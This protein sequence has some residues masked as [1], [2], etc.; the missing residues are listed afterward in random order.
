MAF[1]K[2]G[3]TT[4]IIEKNSSSKDITLPGPPIADDIVIYA[5]CADS[6]VSLG[7]QT[8]GYTDIHTDHNSLLPG[9]ESGYKKMGATPDTVI[10]F[11]QGAH[12]DTAGVLQVWRGQDTTTP[13]DATPTTASGG[14]GNPDC[15][16]ITTNTANA[17]VF[18]IG[19]LDDDKV[20]ASVTAPSGY[21]NLLA[22]QPTSADNAT[23]MIASKEV[24]SAGAED[25]AAF[26]GPGNDAWV[27][28]TFAL[29]QAAGGAPKTV[30]ASLAA[31][32][33]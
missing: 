1:T 11:D 2:V 10:N 15:P 21:S 30:T 32:L 4:F 14:S 24:A 6:V 8:S 28:V 17:L 9:Y 20:A 13:E 27:A 33:Q 29:R 22:H 26:G 12:E 18:A 16:S 5:Q 23:I 7:V 31:A 25:P 19:F 3:E